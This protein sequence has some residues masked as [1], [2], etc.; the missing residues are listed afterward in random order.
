M[1]R[2]EKGGLILG[3]LLILLGLLI[4]RKPVKGAALKEDVSSKILG[5]EFV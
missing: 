1:T 5:W 3:A 4:G 2:Q